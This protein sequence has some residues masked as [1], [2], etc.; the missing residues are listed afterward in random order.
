M[1]VRQDGSMDDI[2]AVK[3]PEVFEICKPLQQ[4]ELLQQQTSEY[5]SPQG[6]LW[7]LSRLLFLTTKTFKNILH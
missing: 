3:R 6:K 5:K 4:E 7:F 2:V 1:K